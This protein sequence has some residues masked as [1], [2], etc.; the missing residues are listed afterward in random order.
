VVLLLTS[1][2]PDLLLPTLVS[3]CQVVPL[4]PLAPGEI[5]E[6]LA[7]RWEV[8]PAEAERLAGLAGG[9]LGWAVEAL[10]RPELAEGREATLDSILRLVTVARD[11]RLRGA[12]ALASDVEGACAA[13]EAW[14]LWWR[15]VLLAAHSA[16]D[17][18]SSGEARRLAERLGRAVGPEQ[19][20]AFL[21]RLLATRQQLDQNVNPRLALEVLALD[22]PVPAPRDDR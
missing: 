11:A 1:A 2:E 20:E 22:M 16:P 15:D 6:A 3:R 10:Q 21:R 18:T 8:P 19:A 13:V 14:A 17:L 4:H 9:R 12:A 7:R 5:A